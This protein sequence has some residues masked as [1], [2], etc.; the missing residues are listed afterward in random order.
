MRSR[1][2][3]GQP[4]LFGENFSIGLSAANPDNLSLIST[5]QVFTPDFS[6]PSCSPDD[7]IH[8][9]SAVRFT[10]IKGGDIDRD[11]YLTIP[12]STAVEPSM[13]QRIGRQSEYLCQGERCSGWQIDLLDPP[14]GIFFGQR[15]AQTQ[16]TGMGGIAY[17]AHMQHTGLTSN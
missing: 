12:V 10:C 17:L 2:Q 16:Q 15:S 8:S 13:T 9:T 7:H 1:S 3:S 14:V 5:D 11:E 6:N 4:L